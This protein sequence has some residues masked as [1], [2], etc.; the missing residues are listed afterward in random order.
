MV[1]SREPVLLL[2]PRPGI[3]PLATISPSQGGG[4]VVSGVGKRGGFEVP[5][6]D[7]EPEEVSE[8]LIN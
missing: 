3:S 2:D 4:G 5:P 8:H 7:F 6:S 1:N